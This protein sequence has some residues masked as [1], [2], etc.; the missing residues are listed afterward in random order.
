MKDNGNE[1]S[2]E[3]CNGILMEGYIS[4]HQMSLIVLSTILAGNL[5]KLRLAEVL[6]ERHLPERPKQ[7][8]VDA[9]RGYPIARIP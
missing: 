3:R 7:R 2:G 4:C 1:I 5:A 9:L 6:E 8:G